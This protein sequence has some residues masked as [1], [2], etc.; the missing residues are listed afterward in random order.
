MIFFFSFYRHS[1][2][3]GTEKIH[4]L[5]NGRKRL[6]RVM[7]GR[8]ISRCFPIFERVLSRSRFRGLDVYSCGRIDFKV[9]G[10]EINLLRAL[11]RS[12]FTSK[13]ETNKWG[14][15]RKKEKKKKQKSFVSKCG[16]LFVD[17]N[18]NARREDASVRASIT[19]L[20]L[21]LHTYTIATQQNK[22][23]EHGSIS[24]LV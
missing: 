11:K 10:F 6:A 22:T 20:R 5:R 8:E 3:V 2:V 23:I 17:K 24:C 7:Q 21:D 14:I 12:V 16:W 18:I 19:I 1:D 9:W 15:R 4:F 13:I